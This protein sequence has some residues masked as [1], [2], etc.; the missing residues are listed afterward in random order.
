[1]EEEM[2]NTGAFN[3]NAKEM[4]QPETIN[5]NSA[6]DNVGEQPKKRRLFRWLIVL[7]AIAIVGAAAGVTAITIDKAK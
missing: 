5:E 3:E 4:Q 6:P 1:M 2:K 7:L